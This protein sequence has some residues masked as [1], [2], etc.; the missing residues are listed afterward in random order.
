M[1]TMPLLYGGG[2]IDC[3]FVKRSQRR[4]GVGFVIVDESGNNMIVIDPGANEEMTVGDVDGAVKVISE[5]ELLLLQLESPPEVSFYAAQ[6]AKK[7]GTSVILNPA[8]AR[9]I[10]L[11]LCGWVDY[12]TPNIPEFNF[13]AGRT[14]NDCVDAASKATKFVEAG[15]KAVIVTMGERGAF[16]VT[17]DDHYVAPAPRVEVMD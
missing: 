11:E 8:P 5:A 4:T 10:S 2:G 1:G 13:L 7:N 16:V 9:Q 3:A 15:V 6:L 14:A 17:E 12:L